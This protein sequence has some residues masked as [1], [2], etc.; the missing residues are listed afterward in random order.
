[1]CTFCFGIDF[2]DKFGDDASNLLGHHSFSYRSMLELFLWREASASYDA[3]EPP[4]AIT[5]SNMALLQNPQRECPYGS[6]AAS[7][8]YQ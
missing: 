3:T 4:E 5:H 6:H 2:K 1:M 8:N 7:F